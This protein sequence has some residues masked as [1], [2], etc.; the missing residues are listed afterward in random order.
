MPSR[1]VWTYT[2]KP[3]KLDPEEKTVFLNRAKEAIAQSEK[4]SRVIHRI[5][6]KNGCIYLYEL[7]KPMGWNDPKS[8]F[9]KPLIDGKYNESIFARITLHDKKGA[10]C[11]A[12]WQRYTGQWIEMHQGTLSECLNFII[13]GRG[14]FQPLSIDED[15]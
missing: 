4:L 15:D 9:I 14:S 5:D 11:T 6:I 1:K 13:S 3:V 12:D 10:N 2:P 8:I 7:Y